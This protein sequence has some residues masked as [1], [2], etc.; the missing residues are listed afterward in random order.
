MAICMRYA[1]NTEDAEQ[2]LQDGYLKIFNHTQKYSGIGNLEGWLRKIITNT[3]LDNLRQL[4]TQYNSMHFHTKEISETVYDRTVVN[5]ALLQ[6]DA[7]AIL[8]LINELPFTQKMVFNLFAIDGYNHK[9][10][11]K[12]LQI[13]EANS[14]WH[15]NQA[16]QSLKKNLVPNTK[17]N[18][19]QGI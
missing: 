13:T 7:A 17:Q 6:M 16:R 14:Q 3:C 8:N 15:L 1:N 9:E 18:E 10:V 5:D 19:R 11:A 12:Q 2:W 4:K